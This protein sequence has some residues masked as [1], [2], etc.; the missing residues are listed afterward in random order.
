MANSAEIA[1][2]SMSAE[3]ATK[4]LDTIT[5]K[6]T[7]SEIKD[8]ILYTGRH[9]KDGYGVIDIKLKGAKRHSPMNVHR[10]RYMIHV[11]KIKLTPSD[12]HVSHLCHTKNCVNISHLSFEP[13]YINNSRQHCFSE[14][15]CTSHGNYK[16]CIL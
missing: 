3:F 8:C 2:F 9:D 5:K 10:I 16:D 12:F 13:S 11:Q 6:T 14:K 1:D 7:K 4:T 15:K